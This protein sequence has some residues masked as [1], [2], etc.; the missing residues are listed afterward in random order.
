[1]LT[2][3]LDIAMLDVI[4]PPTWNTPMGNVFMMI[5]LVGRRSLEN[6]ISGLMKSKQ[7]PAT[8]PNCTKVKVTGYRNC[9]RM[10]LPVLEDRADVVY[11]NPQRRIKRMVAIDGTSRLDADGVWR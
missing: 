8:K 9:V 6:R 4:C 2:G 3:I 11:H 5:A 7:Y 1:M 10:A